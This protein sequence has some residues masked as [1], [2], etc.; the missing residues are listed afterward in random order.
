MNYS[1]KD[2]ERIHI[3]VSGNIGAGKSSLVRALSEYYQWHPVYEPSDDNPYLQDFYRDMHQWAFPTQVYFLTSRFR[4]AVALQ[5]VK[6]SI[7]QDRTIYEDAHIFALNLY[8][9][10]F[11]QERD[12]QNYLGLYHSMINF[13]QQPNLLIYLKGSVPTFVERIRNRVKSENKRRYENTIS[14]EYLSNLNLLYEQWI[15]HF[16]TCKILTIDIDS[17]D[18]LGNEYNFKQLIHRIDQ[19]LTALA[20]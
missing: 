16:N 15:Q 14:N 4:Q 17:T 6:K 5:E 1:K 10:G 7:V 8:Q 3:A 20:L 2:K 12:Y 18:I 13:V 9:S 11:L 19:E